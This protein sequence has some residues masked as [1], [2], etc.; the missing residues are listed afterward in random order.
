MKIDVSGRI[1]VPMAIGGKT[2]NMLIDT[3]GFASMLME[4]TV[5]SLD[6]RTHEVGNLRVT[7][8]GGYFYNRFVEA[9]DITLGE[10]KQPSLKFL[11][12]GDMADV[13]GILSPDILRNFDLDFDFA[14]SRL[15][16]FRPGDCEGQH[17]WWTKDPYSVVSFTTDRS[18]HIIVPVTLDGKQIDAMFDTGASTSVLDLETAESLFGFDE[19]DARVETETGYDYKFPFK[20]LSFGGVVVKNPRLPLIKRVDTGTLAPIMLVGINVMRMLHMYVS[21]P[22]G[23]IYITP[24]SA[25]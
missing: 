15:T 21:Y 24:A 19:K 14:N 11:V 13:G 4:S 8:F 1:D 20:E 12:H 3:G 16:L 17:V 22:E 25:H 5:K 6:L 2:F 18:Q 9:D 10:L 7:G 23:K